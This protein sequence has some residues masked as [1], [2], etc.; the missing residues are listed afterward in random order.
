VLYRAI[1]DTSIGLVR[2]KS[3]EA[4]PAELDELYAV[5]KE[6]MLDIKDILRNMDIFLKRDPTKFPLY[7]PNETTTS[8]DCRDGTCVQIKKKRHFG[9]NTRGSRFAVYNDKP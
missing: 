6:A 2:R 9:F 8:S 4:D 7:P 3:L 1:K 5:K